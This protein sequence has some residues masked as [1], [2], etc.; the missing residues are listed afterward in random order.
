V[1]E[2]NDT[3][4]DCPLP[5]SQTTS[6]TKAVHRDLPKLAAG[7]APKC[8]VESGGDT[9][10]PHFGRVG[11]GNPFEVF[12]GRGAR[13]G[14]DGR[15]VAKFAGVDRRLDDAALCRCPGKQD[16]FDPI[17]LENELEWRMVKRGIAG[18]ENKAFIDARRERFDNITTSASVDR[19]LDEPGGIPTPVVVRV[20]DVNDREI[21]GPRGRQ[22]VGHT[23]ESR[24]K[25]RK[26]R[27]PIL[28]A[29]RVD[30][31]DYKKSVSH[32]PRSS[33]T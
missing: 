12:V 26:Q 1:A 10:A 33:P 2:I 5:T 31:V 27:A 9:D 32:K 19:L 25:R 21:F 3:T 24:P 17:G 4:R 13:R 28:V 15:L 16:P 23:R 8:V 20:V 7:P 30:N 18:L 11:E 14:E 6:S 29:E 22:G